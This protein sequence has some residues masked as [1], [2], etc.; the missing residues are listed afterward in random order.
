MILVLISVAFLGK[1]INDIN[2]FKNYVNTSIERHGGYTEQAELEIA[3]HSK[4]YYQELFTLSSISTIG[5]ANY[6]Q[7]IDYVIQGQFPVAF[8]S[9]SYFIVN[10]NGQAS[11]RLR[12]E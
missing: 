3:T 9:D 6:G 8:F 11:S 12:S 10:F 5:T 4:K 7:S 2:A 1:E